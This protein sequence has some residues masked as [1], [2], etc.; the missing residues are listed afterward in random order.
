MT[1]IYVTEAE[2]LKGREKAAPLTPEMESNMKIL[3]EKINLL[4]H[5]CGIPFTVT[6]G[7]RPANVNASA[8]GA[9]KSAHLTCEAIDI[10]DST[11][12][13]KDWILMNVDVLEELDLY[14]EDPDKTATWVHLQTRR[15]KNRIFKI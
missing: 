8:G 4:R 11:K 7:Y 9:K 6:S 15:T 3:L 12:R 5:K 14:M 1:K 2:Y 13:L 10:A